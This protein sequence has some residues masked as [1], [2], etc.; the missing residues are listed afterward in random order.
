ME[1]LGILPNEDKLDLI[2]K[3]VNSMK[4]VITP[5]VKTNDIFASF[6]DDWGD[7]MSSEEYADMLRYDNLSTPR[8]VDD[9]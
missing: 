3:L 5:K 6:S 2:S 7:G 9:W 4:N 8:S 1:M